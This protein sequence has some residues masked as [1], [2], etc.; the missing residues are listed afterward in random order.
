M[1]VEKCVAHGPSSLG[2]HPSHRSTPN[3]TSTA[4]PKLPPL[5][6]S[7]AS[8]SDST[9]RHYEVECVK[10]GHEVPDCSHAGE[11][12]YPISSQVTRSYDHHVDE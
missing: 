1:A 2:T 3:V 10:D 4:T 6:I 12:D 7:I 11:K 5:S 8:R 9:E